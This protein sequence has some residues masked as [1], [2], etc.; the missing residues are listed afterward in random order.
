MRFKAAFASLIVLG[1]AILLYAQ[2]AQETYQDLVQEC[3]STDQVI[4]RTCERYLK[5]FVDAIFVSG[6]ALTYS[7]LAKSRE[8]CVPDGATVEQVRRIIISH[9]SKFPQLLH[10]PARFNVRDALLDAFP[11]G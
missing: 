6:E 10:F 2:R 3:E 8:I 9:A 11:C 7:G 1:L 5:G 4:R